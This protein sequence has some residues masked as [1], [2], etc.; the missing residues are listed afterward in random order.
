MNQPQQQRRKN[1]QGQP[2]RRRPQDQLDLY[3]EVVDSTAVDPFLD[4]Q[5]LGLG[6]YTSK[7][8]WQQ[9]ESY[10][11]GLYAAA[12]FRRLLTER[13]KSETETRLAIEGWEVTIAGTKYTWPGWD[14]LSEEKRREIWFDEEE[15]GGLAQSSEERFDRRRWIDRR[16][17]KVLTE[18]HELRDEETNTYPAIEALK[19]LSGWEDQWEPAHNRMMMMRHESSRSRGAQLL[20]NVFGRVKREVQEVKEG[21]RR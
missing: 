6:N 15:A 5:N 16:G 3:Q 7:E 17:E 21:L 4:E 20:D 12:G 2:N 11:N 9:V 10:K 18:L 1:G 13:A 14:E 8:M 19:T